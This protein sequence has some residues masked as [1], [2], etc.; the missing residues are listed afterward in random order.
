LKSDNKNFIRRWRLEPKDPIAYAKGEVEP[1]KPIVY[2]LI[3]PHP[4]NCGTSNKG[5]KIG[6]SL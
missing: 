1:I 6:K 3:L 4:K 2:Y 5:L